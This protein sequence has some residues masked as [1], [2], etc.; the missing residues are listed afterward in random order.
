MTIQEVVALF[1]KFKVS[2][3]AAGDNLDTCLGYLT[4]L[5][6]AMLDFS[7]LPPAAPSAPTSAQQQELLLA[8]EIL[9]HGA[10][11]SIK[12]MDIPAFE[13]YVAQLKIYYTDCA[14][15]LTESAK[16]Y[17]ILGLNLLR[18]LAQNRIAEFHTELELIPAPLQQSNIYIKYPAQL[19]QHIMEGSYNKVLSAKQ[20]GL[21]SQ[22]GMYFMDMLVDTVREEI[23]ECSEKAYATIGAAD[24]QSLL[25]LGS[26]DELGEYADNR[27]WTIS[28]GT[29]SFGKQ[30]ESLLQLPSSQLIRETL[31]Y[32]KELERIV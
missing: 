4:Q 1:E 3:N 14:A 19:E 29:V 25:M 2:F 22:E 7:S 31:S 28:N 21:F 6:L 20:D 10:L 16:Q 17:P 26:A 8:R 30:E 11:L 12:T 27:G 18:L 15:T 24:L 13:R 9:E 23:A 32:A 5:K